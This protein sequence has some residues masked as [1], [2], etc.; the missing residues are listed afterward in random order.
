ME[1]LPIWVKNM[2]SKR[3]IR[4]HVL[5]NRKE[6]SKREWEENS[7]LIYER[8]VSHHFFLNADEIYCYVD[9]KNEVGTKKILES[10]WSCQKKVAVPKIFGDDMRFYYIEKLD[11]LEEGY[12]GILEP[13]DT[14]EA[15]GSNVLVIMP[16]A[17]FDKEKHR[18]GY[19]KGFY[20]KYLEKHPNYQTMALAF[21]MQMV[22]NIPADEYDICPKII[23][24]EE[25]IYA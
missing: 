1:V 20:D 25:H 21:E 22:E 15:K 18:I 7:Q 17:A 2:V 8:V 9:F 12:F 13:I 11:E 10:A 24:T 3:D 16:G 23:I 5:L 14:R 19:G 6:M 4:K